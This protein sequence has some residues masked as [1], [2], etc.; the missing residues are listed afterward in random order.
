MCQDAAQHC[1]LRLGEAARLLDDDAIRY[2]PYIFPGVIYAAL[3]TG[4]A[5]NIKRLKL[6]R[7]GASLKK[8]WRRS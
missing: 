4:F 5:M 2:A 7:P 1:L 8:T 6:V 3:A